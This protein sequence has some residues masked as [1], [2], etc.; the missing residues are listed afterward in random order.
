MTRSSFPTHWAFRL[1]SLSLLFISYACNTSA[2]TPPPSQPSPAAQPTEVAEELPGELTLQQEMVFGPGSFI[3]T[4]TRAGLANLAAYQASLTLTFEGTQ[5]GQPRKWSQTYTLL[6]SNEPFARTWTIEKSGDLPDLEPVFLAEMNGLDYERRGELECTATEIQEGEA[7]TDRLELAS[8]LTGVIGAEDAG[9]ETVNGVAADH[10]TF[11]QRALGEQDLT[12]A[13]GE[14][15]V[16]SEGGYIVKYLLT[17]K[18]NADYFG[19]GIEGLLTLA[20]EL[21]D[22]TQ[23]VTIALPEGC[24]PGLVDAPLLPDAA[25][26]TNGPG[27]L[28]YET[29]APLA[30]AAAF[31]QEQILALGWTADG[32]PYLE[33]SK[34]FLNYKL[35]DQR[36]VIILTTSDN[37]TTV[38]ILLENSQ[39]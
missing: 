33:E 2:G 27:Q 3:Y 34:A 9:S 12:E 1:F 7:L 5:A 16:A 35:N 30:D 15:W 19:E 10:Y 6:A 31:Y 13:A 24:P 36:M 25:N 39:Q 22:P 23:P 37:M 20:Y 11:D 29:A 17:T 38:H 28:S 32:E 18:G 26:V 14:L 8:F 4:D 21:S